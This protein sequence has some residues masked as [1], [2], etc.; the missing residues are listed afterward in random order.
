MEQTELNESHQGNEPRGPW[1]AFAIV[2]FVSG[3]VGLALAF[4][5]IFGFAIGIEGLVL[6]CLGQKSI[7]QRKKADIG[8]GLNI[9]AIAIGFIWIIVFYAVL[10]PFIISQTIN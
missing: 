1:K 9:A 2:G 8:V 3:I 5:P 6:S 4:I 10:L 7:I